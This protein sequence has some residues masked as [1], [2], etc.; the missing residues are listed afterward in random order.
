M[1]NILKTGSHREWHWLST[2]AIDVAGLIEVAGEQLVLGKYVAIVSFDSGPY[3]PSVEQR[4]AGW[5]TLDNIAYSPKIQSVRDVPVA[6]WEEFYTFP[7]PVALPRNVIAV[8]NDYEFTLEDGEDP[9]TKTFWNQMSLVD[10]ESCVMEGA[11]SH[12]VSKDHNT[13]ARIWEQ[14]NRHN[15]AKD[16]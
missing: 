4:R 11:I 13:V 10:P 9:L 1:K 14:L 2:S 12:V 6:G 7:D 8:V 15:G 5:K 16:C 3:R